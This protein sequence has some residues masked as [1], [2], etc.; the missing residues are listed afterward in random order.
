MCDFLHLNVKHSFALENDLQSTNKCS[1][2]Q[3]CPTLCGLMDQAPLSLRC[4]KQG[5]WRALPCPPPGHLTDPGIESGSLMSFA[6]MSFAGGFIFYQW[7]QL[8]IPIY[9]YENEKWKWCHSVM[10]NSLQ[11]HG[12]WPTK[13]LNPWNFPSKNT[14]VVAISFS[15]GSSWSRYQTQVSSIEGRCFYHLSHQGSRIC[16]A[17]SRTS[18]KFRAGWIRSWNWYC[19]EKCQ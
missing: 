12:L 11:S 18:C 3:L 17:I 2:A 19:Q 9:F 8:G 6:L 5:Y 7:S 1:V 4:S 15:R 13:L 14:I 16:K 10:S